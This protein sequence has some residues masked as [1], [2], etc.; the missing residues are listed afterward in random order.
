MQMLMMG[1][2]RPCGVGSGWG[3][4]I[5]LSH[6]QTGWASFVSGRLPSIPILPAQSFVLGLDLDEPHRVA[7]GPQLW[8]IAPLTYV[9]R[10]PTTARAPL[11][12]ILHHARLLHAHQPPPPPFIAP[13]ASLPSRSQRLLCPLRALAQLGPSSTARLARR[14]RHRAPRR[15]AHSCHCNRIHS[16]T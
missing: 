8:L 3:F 11:K 7:A 13:P 6:V 4:L 5:I 9:W 1:N 10:P 2:R 12:A 16:S 14:F 15:H